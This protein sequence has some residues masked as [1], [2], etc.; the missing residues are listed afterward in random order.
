MN[1]TTIKKRPRFDK[2]TRIPASEFASEV[3]RVIQVTKY[4]RSA[5]CAEMGLNYSR[6]YRMYRGQVYIYPA[7]MEKLKRIEAAV[8]NPAPST[9]PVTTYNDI[10][11]N[12]QRFLERYV[13]PTPV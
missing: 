4:S 5:V 8:L 7:H 3:D 13:S 1:T 6:F 11:R 2:S 9:K 12:R 10:L